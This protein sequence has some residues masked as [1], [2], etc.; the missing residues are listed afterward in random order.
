MGDRENKFTEQPPN[1][2]ILQYKT[3]REKL[4]QYMNDNP[5]MD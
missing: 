4:E 3:S 1:G 2:E 5:E